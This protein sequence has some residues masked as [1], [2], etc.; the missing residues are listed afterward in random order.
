[1][2]GR[3]PMHS[4]SRAPPAQ[5]VNALVIHRMFGEKSDYPFVPIYPTNFSSRAVVDFRFP[6]SCDAPQKEIAEKLSAGLADPKA[7]RKRL[8]D[9]GPASATPMRRLT[10]SDRDHHNEIRVSRRMKSVILGL[11]H[12]PLVGE[13]ENHVPSDEVTTRLF[14][15]VNSNSRRPPPMPGLG[16]LMPSLVSANAFRA[17]LGDVA[18]NLDYRSLRS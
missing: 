8:M 13:I 3:Q 15:I 12:A 5:P 7:F 16:A 18:N 1:M 4:F 14:K 6:R 11:R 9:T 17:M 10:R 2:A